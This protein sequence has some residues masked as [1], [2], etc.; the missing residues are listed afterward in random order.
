M[1]MIIVII[2]TPVFSQ[3][4]FLHL[5]IGSKLSLP[6]Y[7]RSTSQELFGHDACNPIKLHGRNG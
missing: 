6:K 3:E 4:P 1:M 2:A 5:W 7:I